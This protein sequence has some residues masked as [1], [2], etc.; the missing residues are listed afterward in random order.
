[1][2]AA[3]D[4]WEAGLWALQPWLAACDAAIAAGQR[5]PLYDPE[6]A[7]YANQVRPGDCVVNP[8]AGWDGDDREV[9]DVMHISGPD[10]DGMVMLHAPGGPPVRVA[11]DWGLQRYTQDLA[12]LEAIILLDAASGQDEG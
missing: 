6:A 3:G 8:D 5:P 9:L 2:S 10:A 11:G 7:V 1:V 12:D 4:Y